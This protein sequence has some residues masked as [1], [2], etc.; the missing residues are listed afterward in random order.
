L[1]AAKFGLKLADKSVRPTQN[2]S[3]LGAVNTKHVDP[4]VA[5][6]HSR[7]SG[8]ITAPQPAL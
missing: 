7:E 5:S 3:L 8:L 1:E 2:R 4:R 6:R